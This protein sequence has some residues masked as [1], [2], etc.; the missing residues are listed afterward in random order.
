MLH[1][2]F[3]S[4]ANESARLTFASSLAAGD[5]GIV[6]RQVD[7]GHLWM[8]QT[9]P[10]TRHVNLSSGRKSAS[11]SALTS[12]APALGDEWTIVRCTSTSDLTVTLPPASSV[13]FP[14][15]ATIHYVQAAAG[16][17][18][19]VG[20]AG[21]TVYAGMR[22]PA[23]TSLGGSIVATKIDTDTWLLSG[24]LTDSVMSLY[25]LGN[26]SAVTNCYQASAPVIG[27]AANTSWYAGFLCVPHLATT[28]NMAILSN[29]EYSNGRGFWLGMNI[30][31]SSVDLICESSTGPS[32]A[33]SVSAASLCDAGKA[34]YGMAVYDQP[35]GLLKLYANGTF[36]GSVPAAGYAAATGGLVVGVRGDFPS[37]RFQ[38]PNRLF[39]I[40]GGQGYAPS[41][42]E[43]ADMWSTTLRTR[44][45]KAARAQDYEWDFTTIL[46]GSPPSI[47]AT[48]TGAAIALGKVGAVG[49]TAETGWG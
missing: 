11:S 4:V 45:A 33:V 38:L 48:T 5:N 17:I 39:G 49:A 44:K 19:I 35:A 12:I 37:Y 25:N 32:A 14:V 34:L 20:G 40:C 47:Q 26:G 6:V 3:S 29:F 2:S 7:T 27:T 36:R 15:G 13:P 21:V 8:I 31:A 30:S 41:H 23:T 43:V 22:R 9:V 42:A 28:G 1:A 24:D 10:S 46:G 18:W 16:R